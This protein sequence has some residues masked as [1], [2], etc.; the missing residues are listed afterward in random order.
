MKRRQFL[1]FCSGCLFAGLANAQEWSAPPRLARPDVASDEGGLWALMDREE[2]RLR[3]SP[4]AL[5]DP[6][7]QRYVQDIACRLATEHCADLRVHLVRTPF[8]NA[9][10]AP[11]GMMQVWTGLLLRVDNEAQLAAVIGHEIGHYLQRHQLDRLRDVKKRSAFGQFLGMFGLVGMAGQVGLLAGMFAYGREHE[12]E[13]DRIGSLLMRRAGYD[14]AEAAN[15]WENLQ[16]ELKA[17]ADGEQNSPLFATHPPAEE[18][19]AALRRLAEAAPGGITNASAWQKRIAPYLREW[20]GDEVKRGQHEESIALLTRKIGSYPANAEYLHAR[21]EAYR[22]R[23]KGEDLQTALADYQVAASLG[24]EPAET[25]RGM[26]LVFR[27]IGD[28]AAARTH[29]QRYLEKAPDAPDAPMIR[30]YL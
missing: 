13:A 18:R 22:L 7:L 25:H 9:T 3:R 12:S 21:A 27:A 14:A 8:F 24:G 28:S 15:I 5:R 19:Q 11:N 26:G 4:F 30:S 16:L 2:A 10:M 17:R 1:S 23:A 6:H 29:F 20:L